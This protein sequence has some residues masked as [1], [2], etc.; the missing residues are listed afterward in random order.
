[1]DV[2]AA[3]ISDALTGHRSKIQAEVPL[4][5]LGDYQTSLKS[6]TG[7]EGMFTM[8]FDHYAPA[9]PMVQ[10]ALEKDFRPDAES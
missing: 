9:P 3:R 8:E 2:I 1:M 7:G 4:A 5:E 6:M 10:K